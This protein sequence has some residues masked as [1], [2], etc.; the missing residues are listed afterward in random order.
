M[1]SVPLFAAAL[2]VSGAAATPALAQSDESWTGGYV[3]L[4]GGYRFQPS[5]KDEEIEFDTNLDGTFGD[6]VASTAAPTTNVFSPGF[7]G[8]KAK[9]NAPAGGCS[10][11]KDK[12]DYGI[13]AGYDIQMGSLVVGLVGEYSRSGITDSV[14]AFS[15]TPASYTLTR[16][17]TDTAGLRLRA[18]VATGDTLFFVTGGGAWGKIKN[19]FTTTNTTNTFATNGNDDAWG[20]KLGGG[21]EHRLGGGVSLGLQY[22]FTSLKDDGYRVNARGG[23]AGNPFTRVN[24]GG[25]DFR[26]TG[27]KF[28]SSAVSATINYRF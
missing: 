17:L 12:I 1:K 4:Q 8:G 10:S 25:T 3:G 16:K 28:N 6:T 11:D 19:R 22:I 24:A 9:T 14:S 7:C 2:I 26:R 27:D 15:T 21:V 23:A 5:D 18:G 20:Y 13:H